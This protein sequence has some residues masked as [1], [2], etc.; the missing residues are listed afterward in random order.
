MEQ[1]PSGSPREGKG[2]LSKM[3][4]LWLIGGIGVALMILASFFQVERYVPTPTAP[5]EPEHPSAAPAVARE[6]R[7]LSVEELERKYEE[8]LKT[9]LEEV[10]GTGRVSVMVNLDSTGELVVEKNVQDRQQTTHER[11]RQG[12]TRQVEDHSVNR[13]AVIYRQGNEEK[14]LILMQKRPQVRGVIIVAEGA[15]NPALKAWI[16][17]AV[18]RGLGVPPHRVAILPRK[19]MS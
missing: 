1:P 17:E 9:M 3:Q 8:E 15:E 12:A 5:S 6:A 4:W 2:K 10:V 14:P 18:Q 13:Q 7:E 16:M 19:Q 11:D